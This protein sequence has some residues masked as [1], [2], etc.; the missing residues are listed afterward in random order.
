MDCMDSKLNPQISVHKQAKANREVVTT[1]LFKLYQTNRPSDGLERGSRTFRR[2]AGGSSENSR[3]S[4]S[5]I[6][7]RGSN[8]VCQY[9]TPRAVQTNTAPRL[10]RHQGRNKNSPCLPFEFSPIC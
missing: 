6:G 4:S 1:P 10:I 2:L 3:G 7:R 5:L 8:P 9:R